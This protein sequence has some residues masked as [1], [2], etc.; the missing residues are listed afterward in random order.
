MTADA[1]PGDLREEEKQELLSLLH[2]GAARAV[3]LTP[4]QARLWRLEQEQ[5][6]TSFYHITRGARIRGPLDVG[7]LE[8]ALQAVQEHHPALSA[9]VPRVGDL[10]TAVLLLGGSSPAP[11]TFHDVEGHP[12]DAREAEAARIA[13]DA[14]ERPFDLMRGPLCRWT[15]VRV[16]HEDHLL[17]STLHHLAVDGWSVR[18]LIRDVIAFYNAAIAGRKH[19]PAGQPMSHGEYAAWEARNLETERVARQTAY[20]TEELGRPWPSLRLSGPSPRP[21]RP[22]VPAAVEQRV[23]DQATV[24]AL[25][26]LARRTG[27][28]L[29]V[30]ML[31]AY[32]VALRRLAD[33]DDVLVTVHTP[34]RFRPEISS[35][36]GCFFNPV[37]LRI[38]APE[39]GDLAQLLAEVRGKMLAALSNAEVPYERVRD[40]LVRTGVAT[41]PIP[42]T[43]NH[44]DHID[45]PRLDPERLTSERVSFPR[46]WARADLNLTTWNQ[47]EGLEVQFVYAKWLMDP[48]A[49]SGLMHDYV[50]V[51]ERAIQDPRTKLRDIRL[52]PEG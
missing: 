16:A 27:V 41:Y 48:A 38:R 42:F 51:L 33:T 18:I 40:E 37:V 24:A 31:A 22:L 46:R 43:F 5:P 32:A 7:C 12:V 2:R 47:P 11:L 13:D 30:V 29:F 26:D 50:G 20:W 17:V 23:L 9:R 28:T 25:L 4:A 45:L 10:P 21:A 3:R 19:H 44:L 39:D 35:L 6:G 49:A 34:G 1:P 52:G 8:R 36:I 15:L 14:V